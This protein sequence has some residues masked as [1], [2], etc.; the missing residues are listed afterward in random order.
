MGLDF[1]PHRRRLC[2]SWFAV[3]HLNLHLKERNMS[4]NDAD[5]RIREGDP[6]II[7]NSARAPRDDSSRPSYAVWSLVWL[8]PAAVHTLLGCLT[9]LAVWSSD[10]GEAGMAWFV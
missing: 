4:S 3:T 7:P 5:N 10:D 8:L 6:P 2:E 9:C 1:Q